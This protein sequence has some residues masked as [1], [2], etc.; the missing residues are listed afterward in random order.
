MRARSAQ[1]VIFKIRLVIWSIAF[2]FLVAMFFMLRMRAVAEDGVNPAEPKDPP[3]VTQTVRLQ[4]AED[5]SLETVKFGDS[6]LGAGQDGL[7]EL[8]RKLK[9]LVDKTPVEQR[10][11][12]IVMLIADEELQYEWVVKSMTACE[13]WKDPQTGKTETLI[14]KVRLKV[15]E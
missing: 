14:K 10:K 11:Q 7:N 6:P 4:A 8:N 5:G 12:L 3:G 15:P 2:V 1:S 9:E 13:S